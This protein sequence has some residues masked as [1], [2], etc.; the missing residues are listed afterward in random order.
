MTSNTLKLEG[1]GA[2]A[3][4]TLTAFLTEKAGDD[5]AAQ[6]LAPRLEHPVLPTN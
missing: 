6:A 2:I 3:A 5:A 1:D 4:P